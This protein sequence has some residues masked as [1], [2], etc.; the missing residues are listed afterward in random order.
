MPRNEAL[1]DAL[2]SA[3]LTI[4]QLAEKCDVDAKTVERWVSRGRLPHPRTRVRAAGV[5]GKDVGVLWPEA[6]RRA[7]KLGADREL[8]GVY[9]RRSDLPRSLFRELIGGARSRLWFGGYTSY[10]VWLEVPNAAD[11]IGAKAQAGADVRFLL[12]DP[13]SPVTAGRDRIEATPLDLATRIAMTRAEIAKSPTPLAV[14][15]SD[16]HVGMSVWVFDNDAIV[17]THIGAGLGQ[18]SVTLHFRQRESGGPFSRYLAHFDAL[19]AD[20][21]AVQHAGTDGQE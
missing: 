14:R 11:I 17:A 5:L 4:S 12:G 2:T 15:L 21:A 18:D 9:A 13:T 19:W 7:V 8:V 3:G 1:R 6:V 16:R 20:A 10:F